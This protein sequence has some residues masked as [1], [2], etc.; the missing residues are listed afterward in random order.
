MEY[1]HLQ[2]CRFQA[3]ISHENAQAAKCSAH[4]IPHCGC[5]G[6]WNAASS[7]RSALG[8]N[9]M[10]M[11]R[12]VGVRVDVAVSA[13]STG[14]SW[15]QLELREAGPAATAQQPPRTHDEIY[16]TKAWFERLD[17]IPTS[18]RGAVQIILMY[19]SS[20]AFAAPN[21]PCPFRCIPLSDEEINDFDSQL[22]QLVT[23]TDCDTCVKLYLP[24][25]LQLDDGAEDV[26]QWFKETC[27]LPGPGNVRDHKCVLVDGFALKVDAGVPLTE[28]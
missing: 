21:E 28:P 19:N 2:V 22:V 10:F 20:G 3:C 13:R 24:K 25:Q 15:L 1:G 11:I 9:F 16:T 27:Q 23:D 12:W 26:L 4:N 8:L 17:I 6:C 18:V 7:C 14:L 5:H